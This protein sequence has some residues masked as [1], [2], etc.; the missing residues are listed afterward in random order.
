MSNT[1]DSTSTAQDNSGPAIR[2]HLILLFVDLSASSMLAEQLEAEQFADVLAAFRTICRE[3]ITRREGH[4]VRMQGDG[5]LVV[6]GYPTPREDDARRACDSALEVRDLMA[7]LAPVALPAGPHQVGVHSGLH[8]GLVLVAQGDVERGRLELIG[9]APNTAARLAA[10]APPGS[11]YVDV[12]SLGPA[13]KFY[14]FD[15]AR[16]LTLPGKATTV[17]VSG[18]LAPRDHNTLPV[19]AGAHRAEAPLLGRDAILAEACDALASAY[20]HRQGRLIQICGEAG[21]GKTRLLDEL[22]VCLT[23]SGWKCLRG[24]CENYLRAE[25]LRPFIQVHAQL[26]KGLT[27]AEEAAPSSATNLQ[28]ALLGMVGDA[29]GTKLVLLFD[30]WHWADDASRQLLDALLDKADSVHVVIATRPLQDQAEDIGSSL[31]LD[32]MPFTE[33]ETRLAVARWAPGTDPFVAS[34]IHHYAGGVPLWVEELCHALVNSGVSAFRALQ[35]RGTRGGAPVWMSSFVS[36]RLVRLSTT[37]QTLVRTAAVLGT[38]C[39]RALCARVSGPLLES[40][41]EALATADL[42]FSPDAETLRFKHGLTR[43]AVYDLVPLSERK[44]I[45]AK[46][47][48]LLRSEHPTV[49]EGVGVDSLAYHAAGA[50]MWHDATLSFEAAADKAMQAFALDRARAHYHS[51]ID[52]ADRAGNSGR[53][54]T[55]RWCALVQ[56]LGMTCIFDLLALPD[57][58]PIFERAVEKAQALG[59]P[60]NTARSAYWLGYLTY[61]FGQPRK[62][63]Q[64]LRKALGLASAANDLRLAAQVEACLGQ[65]LAAACEYQESMHL[66]ERALI[67]K[68]QGI[69][70]GSAVAVGSAFTLACKASVLADR[71]DFAQAHSALDEARALVGRTLHPVSNSVCNWS[72]VILAWEGRWDDTEAVV[73]ESIRIAERTRALLPLAIA[74]AVGGYARWMRDRSPAAFEEIVQAVSWIEQRRGSYYTSIYYGWLVDGC[75]T[76]EQPER[77]RQYAQR[78]SKRSRVGER[79][80]EAVGWRALALQAQ[81][82]GDALRAD[83][84]LAWAEQSARRRVSRREAALNDLRR[85]EI[86]RLRGTAD[87]ADA[88]ESAACEALSRMGLRR[89]AAR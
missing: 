80:G 37:Q 86:L 5:A 25:V 60:L 54:A 50:G 73:E 38:A 46:V 6:F 47:V 76:L 21:V 75:V 30:D 65:V 83:R 79:L 52:A 41:L 33:A 88:L 87:A 89:P 78:L 49:G 63:A 2:R 61:G 45:H 13:D 31:R 48:A 82:G 69:R 23:R 14:L 59:E 70:T 64:H 62:A 57:V 9:D 26:V 19:S 22:E 3:V 34:E 58:M 74:R 29:I 27:N 35:G 68:Q 55:L 44:A 72:M 16:A 85:S 28:S 10:L 12:E 36:S 8:A 71:G 67:V 77:A 53:E 7:K 17:R 42:L 81:R 43:D 15:E 24:S 40:E 4:V 20:E 32:V 56:K 18:L 1:S 39:S 84:Y 11:I 66:M 51:A